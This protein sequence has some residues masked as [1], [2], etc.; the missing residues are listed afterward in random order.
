MAVRLQLGARQ[1]QLL[2]MGQVI[3]ILQLTPEEIDSHLTQAAAENPILRLRRRPP[4]GRV[5]GDAS[6]LVAA[7]TAGPTSLY[8]H[9]LTDMAGFIARAGG[10]GRIVTALIG[11]LEPSGW[12]G[13]APSAVAA[14]LGLSERLVLSVLEVVQARA[15]PA[16]LFARDLAECLALQLDR[17][18]ALCSE[19]RAVLAHLA[20]MERGG[21]PA[22]AL[23]CGLPQ[24]AVRACLSRLRRLDP[25]PGARFDTASPVLGRAP[26]VRVEAAGAGWRIDFARQVE[27]V[28]TPPEGPRAAGLAEAL[29]RA[30]AL[31]HALELRRSAVETV[32]AALVERQGAYFHRGR[33]ALEPLSLT[34][35]A[36]ATGFHLSTVSRVLNGLLIEGPQGIVEARALCAGAAS[37]R[38]DLS[39]PRVV[40]RIRALL[41]GEDPGAPLSDRAIVDRL[42]AEG[43]VV[44]RRVVA[45]Y[46]QEAGLS[47]AAVRRHSC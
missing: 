39:K 4:P 19:M 6:A 27:L 23:A 15:E 13:R 10:A 2:R 34:D 37:V 44:S 41:A 33:A 42:L 17:E 3:D 20:V 31:R 25:K 24:P 1:S 43:L 22:L 26:D 21:L 16:G 38:G 9:V 29:A 36:R 30:R 11:E 32:V 8:D 12:L 46:R 5:G 45:K 18:G 28:V 14:D 40:A 7:V 35:L 47:A